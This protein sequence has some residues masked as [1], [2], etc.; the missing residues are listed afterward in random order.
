MRRA[1]HFLLLLSFSAAPSAF[2][3]SF[4]K[5]P[6]AASE[7]S[8]PLQI[9]VVNYQGSTNGQMVIELKNPSAG[10]AV[11]SAEGLYFVPDGPADSAPQRLGA[12]GGFDIVHKKETRRDERYTVKPGEAI[13]LK[14]DVYCVDSHRPS[15]TS[16]TPFHVAATRMPRALFDR[17]NNEAKTSAKANGGFAAPQA[18]RSVQQAVWSNRDSDWVELAGEGQREKTKKERPTHAPFNRMPNREQLINRIP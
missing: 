13:V 7:A 17:I 15:P 14:L 3:E 10:E 11:F 12:V 9:R 4:S 16:S 5:L 1:S 2:S 8:N 18:K 6:V